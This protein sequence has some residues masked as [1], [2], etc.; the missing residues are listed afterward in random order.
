MF[1]EMTIPNE[2]LLRLLYIGVFTHVYQLVKG[3][4]YKT[5]LF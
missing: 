5:T 4:N 1:K 2:I 3:K